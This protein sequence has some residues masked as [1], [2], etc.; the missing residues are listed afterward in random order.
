LRNVK[1]RVE[2]W[3][4][5]FFISMADGPGQQGLGVGG[6]LGGINTLGVG[7]SGIVTE[8]PDGGVKQISSE[9]VSCFF[10]FSAQS[11]VDFYSIWQDDDR[12]LSFSWV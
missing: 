9:K 5:T 11:V 7:T 3:H 12:F 1:F 2:F 10:I 6:G 4:F 8:T